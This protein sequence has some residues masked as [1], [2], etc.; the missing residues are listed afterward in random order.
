MFGLCCYSAIVLLVCI[1][2]DIIYAG[3]SYVG[4]YV[5]FTSLRSTVVI[6]MVVFEVF[7]WGGGRFRE[8]CLL[9]WKNIDLGVAV[10]R[11]GVGLWA[12][13]K[14]NLIVRL[15]TTINTINESVTRN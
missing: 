14:N 12:T 6:L 9:C 8:C 4:S 5:F 1:G 13:E 2:F 11:F 10:L 15:Q 3:D 7:F